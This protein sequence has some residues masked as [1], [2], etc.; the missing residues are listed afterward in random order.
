MGG[1]RFGKVEKQTLFQKKEMFCLALQWKDTGTL[2][3]K[4]EE[5]NSAGERAKKNPAFET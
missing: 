1:W 3:H 2:I 5:Y 4:Q